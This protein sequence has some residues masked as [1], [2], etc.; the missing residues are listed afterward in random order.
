MKTAEVI[1][2]VKYLNQMGL[3]KTQIAKHEL[4]DSDRGTVTKI[5]KGEHPWDNENKNVRDGKFTSFIPYV[6]GRL[7]NFPALSSIRIYEEIKELGYEGS[8]RTTRREVAK[9]RQ[10]KETRAILGIAAVTTGV[11]IPS[12]SQR[13]QEYT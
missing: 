13:R 6:E 10:P 11:S 1:S 9:L 4:V 3:N 8:M 7:E 12:R 2:L 5:I